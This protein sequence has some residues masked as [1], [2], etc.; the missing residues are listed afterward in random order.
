MKV[1]LNVDEGKAYLQN[2]DTNAYLEGEF[3][4]KADLVSGKVP[5]AQLPDMDYIPT[6]EK[7]AASGVATLGVDG[8]V[9]TGQLPAMN[10][11]PAAH[12]DDTVKHVTA[13]ER[14]A[15]NAKAP[16][17]H[18]HDDRYYTEAETLASA[19][20]SMLGLGS[21]AVPDDAFKKLNAVA[22]D[23]VQTVMDTATNKLVTVSSMF[24]S[25]SA[26]DIQSPLASASVAYSPSTAEPPNQY[27]AYMRGNILYTFCTIYDSTARGYDLYLVAYNVDTNSVVSSKKLYAAVNST[28][29]INNY[30]STWQCHSH[31]DSVVSAKVT[32]YDALVDLQHGLV[33]SPGSSTRSVFSTPNYWGYIYVNGYK[34]RYLY[35]APRGSTSFTSVSLGTGVNGSMYDIELLGTY[36][37]TVVFYDETWYA[38]FKTGRVNL[39]TGA[40]TSGID[41]C[42]ASGKFGNITWGYMYPMLTTD[43]HAYIHVNF[44]LNNESNQYMPN[45]I[46]KVDLATGLTNFADV[47]GKIEYPLYT[48]D[49]WY[50]NYIGSVGTK[51]YYI[52]G[53]YVTTFDRATDSYSEYTLKEYRSDVLRRRSVK[54]TQFNIEKMPGTIPLGWYYFDTING[55][56]TPYAVG[57]RRRLESATVGGV[58][59]VSQPVRYHAMQAGGL[60]E[61]KCLGWTELNMTQLAVAPVRRTVQFVE[62]YK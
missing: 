21:S 27:P 39:A 10:Y 45:K 60:T 33:Y 38:S 13:T 43:T 3:N 16:A 9:P 20:K 19:T 17:A 40:V 49:L 61:L 54:E 62:E 24:H 22:S 48:N 14:N 50:Y 1:I 53:Q 41:T 59:D 58:F 5:T 6:K 4:K 11:A 42:D 18:T 12:V 36:G 55:C 47:T 26:K 46:I 7:G 52:N 56:Y 44:V 15:W 8:K 28:E 51:A 23:A 25:F 57:T 35:Y 32:N 30:F 29:G 31:D 2:A 34:S 37:D